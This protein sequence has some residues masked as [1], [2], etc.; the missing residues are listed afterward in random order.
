[1]RQMPIHGRIA[2]GVAQAVCQWSSRML[3]QLRG[4]TCHDILAL[5]YSVE[6]FCLVAPATPD[7]MPIEQIQRRIRRDVGGGSVQ[8]SF[9]AVFC[10]LADRLNPV[11]QAPRQCGKEETVMSEDCLYN[12]VLPL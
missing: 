3:R 8:N 12:R 11:V 6:G 4:E 2:Q 10:G 9:G 7:Q 1:M 5:E